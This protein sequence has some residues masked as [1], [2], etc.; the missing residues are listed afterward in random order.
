MPGPQCPFCGNDPY[1]YVDIGV[2]M[3]RVAVTCCELGIEY[4]HPDERDTITISRGTLGSFAAV[5]SAM[6]TLGM[7]PD[8]EFD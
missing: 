2:G 4:F 3:E 5:F 1:E 7:S 8:I 6:R